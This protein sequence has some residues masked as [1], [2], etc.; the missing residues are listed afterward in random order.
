MIKKL[1]QNAQTLVTGE[2][3]VEIA[4]RLFSFSETA[5]FFCGLFHDHNINLAA[6]FSERIY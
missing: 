5:E 3:F 6:M 1:H 4:V 2:F